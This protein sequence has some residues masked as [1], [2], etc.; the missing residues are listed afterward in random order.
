MPKTIDDISAIL[1]TIRPGPLGLGYDKLLIQA[2]SNNEH[3]EFRFPKYTH[4]FK[5]TYGLGLYQE[6]YM[7]LL[8]EM[9]GFD[10][11]KTDVW[12][13]AVGKTIDFYSFL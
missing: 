1:A 6:Q 12:R 8:S 11:I 10:P 7:I 4:I 9:C 2:M 13:K 5:D 3:F